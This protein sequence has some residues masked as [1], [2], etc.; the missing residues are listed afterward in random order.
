MRGMLPGMR[1]SLFGWTG[2]LTA[3]SFCCAITSGGT[4]NVQ[5]IDISETRS[6]LTE[7]KDFLVPAAEDFRLRPI[8]RR[9][10]NAPSALDYHNVPVDRD[11]PLFR[12]PLVDALRNGVSGESYYARR[13]GF[14]PPYY[15]PII[16][17]SQEG[18]ARRA[19]TGIWCR[20][21]VC[22]KLQQANEILK[23]YGVELFLWD[24]WRPIE[25]Q[26]A[27][28]QYFI[29]EAHHKLKTDNPQ[30]LRAYAG[31]FCSNPESFDPINPHTW[32]THSTGGAVDL[33][34]RRRDSG[35]LLYMGGTF[36]DA[37]PD[38]YTDYFEPK[39]S[40]KKVSCTDASAELESSS[41]IDAR[42]NRR[43]LYFAMTKAGFVNY[44]YEW[45][46]YDFG[47]QMAA[48]NSTT[49]TSA[50]AVHALYGY[51]QPVP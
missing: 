30:R 27:L 12:E 48:A 25:I 18:E 10:K 35:E 51:T 24:A 49:G 44:P 4:Q 39:L 43:L 41:G 8:P 13:D 14:N 16:G 32:P 26:R 23:P 38:S 28:W 11:S 22:Q 45:W 15:R 37:S 3:G 5:R 6:N 2:L 7:K 34:L 20:K 46:H 33:S 21:T 1:L 17:F 9:R 31:K 50:P 19:P 42:R 47:T 29:E 40:T 36:D